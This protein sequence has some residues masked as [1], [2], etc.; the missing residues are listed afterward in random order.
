VKLGASGAQRTARA[1]PILE[2]VQ[3]GLGA[4][5]PGILRVDLKGTAYANEA[6]LL[7]AIRK[8]AEEAL[9]ALVLEA[10]GLSVEAAERRAGKKRAVC[11]Y[12]NPNAHASNAGLGATVDERYQTSVH[13]FL[14]ARDALEVCDRAKKIDEP[15]SA[16]KHPSSFNWES[17]V[18]GPLASMA[19]G[20]VEITG[21]R[22]KPE[23]ATAWRAAWKDILIAPSTKKPSD[24]APD[25]EALAAAFLG[26]YGRLVPTAEYDAAGKQLLKL[27]SPDAHV[28]AF[29]I[30]DLAVRGVLPV[31]LDQAELPDSAKELRALDAIRALPALAAARPIVE[32]AVQATKAQN[33]RAQALCTVVSP[34][35]AEREPGAPP[36]IVDLYL[37]ALEAAYRLKVPKLDEATRAFF[38]DL[39]SL[40]T[41]R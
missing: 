10:E 9:P 25:G 34:T 17:S 8:H 38:L 7:D 32:R 27:K 21:D 3:K 33:D 12:G 39:V 20:I 24:D 11:W 18:I 26:Y 16:R 13:V 35:L 4:H 40:A 6:I 41:G 1:S 15:W 23:I 37:M 14:L 19:I 30:V 5:E 2:I 22:R 31:V 36:A 29:R 28:V